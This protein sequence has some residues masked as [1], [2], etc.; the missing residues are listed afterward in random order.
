MKNWNIEKLASEEKI[1]K[2]ERNKKRKKVEIKSVP[3][4][5]VC[6]VAVIQLSFC[7]SV[8]HVQRPRDRDVYGFFERP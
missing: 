5:V 3:V 8:C 1:K 6:S 4:S 2:K 7:L